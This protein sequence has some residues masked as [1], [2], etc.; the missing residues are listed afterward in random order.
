MKR[1]YIRF[2][3]VFLL[4]GVMI[5]MFVAPDRS[6]SDRENRYLAKATKPTWSTVFDGSFMDE[7]ETYLSDQ[8]PL[9]DWCMT[10]RSN[11]V[12]LLGQKKINGAFLA[13]DSYLIPQD[14]AV[15]AD[16][17]DEK[18]A[19]INAFAKRY[20][21]LKVNVLLAP[22]AS[23]VYEKKLPAGIKSTQGETMDYV[24]SALST[25]VGFVD[26]RENLLQNAEEQLYF[27]NDHHWT[28]RGAFAAF[29]KYMATQK[30]AVSAKDFSYMTVAEEFFG[31]Q[32][33][34][35][36]IYKKGDVVEICAPK[37]SEGTYTVLFV[38]EEKKVSSLFDE[39]K[40]TEKDKYLVFMGGNYAQTIINTRANNGKRLLIIKDSYANCMIPMFTPYYEQIVVID[41]RYFFDSLD[42]VILMNETD[43]VLFMYSVNGFVTDSTLID[44]LMEEEE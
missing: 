7:W 15:D 13:A 41:P 18:I 34:N 22:G 28:V 36:G 35:S 32:A 9:R 43:E 25:K 14:D 44:T 20:P 1:G 10:L 4:L 23:F 21:D 42:D 38:N 26:V 2:I 5:W 16:K 33:S 24:I 30:V 17:L 3:T 11:A 6:F 31:T 37:D 39:S 8:F 19:S 29:E 27:R 40:V 12:S